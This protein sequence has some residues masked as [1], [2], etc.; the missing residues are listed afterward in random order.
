MTEI[1]NEQ[2]RILQKNPEYLNNILN[3]LPGMVF[4][5]QNNRLW[6]MLYIS[7]GAQAVTGYS[8][9]DL[10]NGNVIDYA[11]IIVEDDHERV[12]QEIHSAL[13]HHQQYETEYRINT[14]Q[15]G[16]KWVRE[17]GCSGSSIEGETE[18][19]E[20]IIID[21]TKQKYAELALQ[22]SKKRLDSIVEGSIEA[23]LIHRDLKALFINK[24][25]VDMLGYN[26]A[27]EILA[28]ESIANLIAP[29]DWN[30]IKGYS[31]ARMNGEYAPEQYEF[32]AQKC[33]GEIRVLQ[34]ESSIMDWN[35]Q[36]AILST[37]IDITER[38]LAIRELEKQRQQLAHMDRLSTLGEMAASIAH[39]INQ[40]L[41]AIS[42]RS[43][44]TRRRIDGGNPD[45]K[46]LRI[47][48]D[49]I[50]QQSQRAGEIMHRIREL[51]KPQSSQQVKVNIQTLVEECINFAEIDG[52][53]R[54]THIITEITTK[55][56]QVIADPVQI[57]QVL[58]NLIRNA[59]QAMKYLPITERQLT[60]GARQHDD[61]TV[62]VTVSDCGCGIEKETEKKLFDSFFTTR[63]TGLGMGLSI[64][65][66][67]VSA[68]NGRLWFTRNSDKGVTFRFT[69]PV[70]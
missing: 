50:E 59:T 66:T 27:D 9:E 31:I 1:I 48:L 22:T 6:S 28:L 21:I 47:A 14:R 56:P 12:W 32:E 10:V 18:I 57:H 58:L 4:R 35:G 70:A 26:C 36:S 11:S 15:D 51:A 29:H 54:D 52:R 19:L 2:I 30:R 55:L 45:M 53:I 44:A 42:N 46:K 65:R 24:S 3:N 62:Q 67:I 34:I 39:E 8:P 40:P 38:K 64:C 60:V 41:T 43:S 68:N 13:K 33:D 25:L 23:I 17:K 63:E 7:M 16:Q 61:Y 37:L 20:G 5:C 49:A 69:L